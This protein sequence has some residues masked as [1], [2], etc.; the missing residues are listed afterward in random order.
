MFKYVAN[1]SFHF[2]NEL[3]ML[4]QAENFIG[5]IKYIFIHKVFMHIFQLI[6]NYA[7]IEAFKKVFIYPSSRPK[8]S[9]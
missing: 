2:E 4:K 1:F 9:F 5:S 7:K 6:T 8:N 3:N